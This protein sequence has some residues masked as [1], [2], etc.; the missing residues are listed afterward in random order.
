MDIT[1]YYSYMFGLDF[2]A[3]DPHTTRVLMAPYERREFD[4]S[5]LQDELPAN[6]SWFHVKPFENGLAGYQLITRKNGLAAAAIEGGVQPTSWT[7]M[8][9]TPTTDD[10]KTYITLLNPTEERIS[11]SVVAFD[12]TGPPHWLHPRVPDLQPGEKRVKTVEEMFGAA[13]AG[14]ITWMRAY[15]NRGQLLSH[16]L[17]SR[18]DSFRHRRPPGWCLTVPATALFSMPISSSTNW[19]NWRASNGSR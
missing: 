9:Y 14:R 18:R 4:V 7:A 19:R 2:M 15:T 3:N 10:L 11:S 8:P 6:A 12:D 13:K 16:A 5:S 1:A 17:I